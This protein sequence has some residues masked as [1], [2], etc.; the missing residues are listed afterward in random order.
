MFL[1]KKPVEEI[2]FYNDYNIYLLS[3]QEVFTMKEMTNDQK[4]KC[5]T[6]IHTFASACAGIGAAPIPGSDIAPLI[7]TQTAM[8]IA[9]G[10]VFDINLNS[11]YAE[12]MAKTAIAG[13]I[14]KIIASEL[15]KLIPGVGSATNAIVAFSITELIG[16]DAA[17]EFLRQSQSETSA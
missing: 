4:T 11:S 17:D 12:S 8:I 10:K 5:H 15:T 13:N 6:I 3:F 7:A 14:G 1:G 9:L 16:W 2:I